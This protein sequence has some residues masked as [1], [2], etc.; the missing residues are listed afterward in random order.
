VNY[1]QSI[2]CTVS[3]KPYWR[4]LGLPCCF[5]PTATPI[6]PLGLQLGAQTLRKRSILSLAKAQKASI[7]V[8]ALGLSAFTLASILRKPALRTGSIKKPLT[9]QKNLSY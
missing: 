8:D 5:N 3:I 1:V 7:P 4:N 6:I 9:L 2:R